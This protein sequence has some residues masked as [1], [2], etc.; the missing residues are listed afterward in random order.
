CDTIDI[1]GIGEK[2]HTRS[3]PY[4]LIVWMFAAATISVASSHATRTKPPRPRIDLYFFALA[5]SSTID[6]QASTGPSVLRASRHSRT[7]RP[8]TIGCL[9]RL[10]LYR[11]QLRR[12]AR[13][14]ARLVVGHPRARPRVI[15]LLRLPGDD[16][17]LD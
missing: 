16:P 8:R 1:A 11:Y 15:G 5:G 2:P 12:A 7:S 3:G 17:A 4:R 6:A 9:R 10:A 14:P 13:T